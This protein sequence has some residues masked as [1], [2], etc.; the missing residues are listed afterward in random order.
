MNIT[1]TGI[2]I[3]ILGLYGMLLSRKFLYDITI[4]FIPFSATAVINVGSDDNGSAIQPFMFLG[5]L[6]LI[7]LVI[8]NAKKNVINKPINKAEMRAILLLV[9]FAAIVLLSLVMPMKINGAEMGNVTGQLGT[10]DPISFSSKNITQY[11]YL[12]FGIIMAIGIYIHN[13]DEYNYKRT[14]KVYALSILFVMFWGG[15]ELLC[16][17]KNINY[18]DMIFN[19]SISKSAGGFKG[20]L[21]EDGLKRISSVAVEPSILVQSVEVFIPFLIFGIIKKQYI[22]NRKWDILYL[23]L[24]YL[25]VFRATSSGGIICLMFLS[26]F[27]FLLCFKEFNIKKKV[28]I[29]ISSAFL[30]PI[31]LLIIYITFQNI[32]NQMLFNKSDSYSSLERIN[33]VFEAW[34]TF[35]NHPILGA[36]WGAVTSYDLF[37]KILSNAGLLG[38]FFFLAFLIVL[39]INQYKT[40]NYFYNQSFIKPAI[41]VSFC[42]LIVSNMISGF[43][44]VFG[45][46]WLATGLV[47][48]TGTNFQ[49]QA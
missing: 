32:I 4:F 46:F 47:L 39:L 5:M 12:I 44:F 40:K 10:S 9:G 36:G 30:M 11:F 14:I 41:L 3:I 23:F 18:P 24:L 25:F 48:I 42:T 31:I 6:W 13:K 16:F 38:L 8:S 21:D 34:A 15:L 35:L 28:L 7:C 45:F 1:Y 33:A 37:V 27:S 29:I 43:S 17:Y 2:V 19:N 49:K 26:M 20:V 22:F